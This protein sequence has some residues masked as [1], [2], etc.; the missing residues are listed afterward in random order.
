MPHPG[1]VYYL[2]RESRED[3][4]KGDRPHVL[5]SLCPPGC[6]VVT[7]AYGSTKATDAHH[8]AEHVLIDPAAMSYR[9]TGLIFPT[10]VYPSRLVSY[11][12]D[13]LDRPAGQLIDEMPLLH[14]RLRRALGLGSGVTREANVAGANRR[15]RIVE[16]VPELAY[17]WEA[18][19]GLVVTEPGYSRTGYQQ[20]VIPVLDSSCET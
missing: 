13:A 6:E 19:Y 17:E 16:L 8:G 10:Y 1:Q 5:L 14:R 15:G 12:T 3:R 2:P 20:T 7:L 9:G 18:G 11:A 4:D